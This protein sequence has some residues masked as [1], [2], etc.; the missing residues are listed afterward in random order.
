M[1]AFEEKRPQSFHLLPAE[2]VQ[3]LQRLGEFRF[4]NVQFRLELAATALQLSQLL[5]FL[6]Q[7][8]CQVR[9]VRHDPLVA[10][11][12]RVQPAK[13]NHRGKLT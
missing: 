11:G 7:E 1:V 4:E 8:A 9:I 5:L 6:R 10:T 13:K 12:L 3:V 2:R